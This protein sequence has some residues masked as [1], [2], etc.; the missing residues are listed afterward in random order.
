MRVPGQLEPLA[1]WGLL[2]R[3]V[4]VHVLFLLGTHVRLIRPSR[5]E[6]PLSAVQLLFGTLSFILSPKEP[7]NIL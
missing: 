4:R 1:G 3:F 7:K 2:A 6:S 5:V